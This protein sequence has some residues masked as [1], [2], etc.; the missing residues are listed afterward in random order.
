MLLHF[1]PF[2]LKTDYKHYIGASND[3]GEGFVWES[4][5]K[6]VDTSIAIEAYKGAVQTE[7]GNKIYCMVIYEKDSGK[8]I[9]DAG[10]GG[11]HF[12]VCQI[13]P[14]KVPEGEEEPEEPTEGILGPDEETPKELGKK[15]IT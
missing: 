6:A 11:N 15:F 14:E 3:R 8:G 4:D 5:G 1:R 7:S 9:D 12:A 13:E 2:F 10:C